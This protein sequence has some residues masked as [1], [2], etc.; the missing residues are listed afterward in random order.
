MTSAIRH[1]DILLGATAHWHHPSTLPA[2]CLLGGSYDSTSIL[3]PPVCRRLR[4]CC[5]HATAIV[6]IL[7]NHKAVPSGAH[8]E[9]SRH[10]FCAREDVTIGQQNAPLSASMLAV[11]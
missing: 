2:C 5:V 10:Q 11:M 7:L 3:V 9:R 6:A 1:L 4:S 8:A